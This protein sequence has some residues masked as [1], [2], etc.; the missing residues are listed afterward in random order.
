MGLCFLVV[1]SFSSNPPVWIRYTSRRSWAFQLLS[2]SLNI[3]GGRDG[4][5]TFRKFVHSSLEFSLHPLVPLKKMHGL[6]FLLVVIL[7][8]QLMLDNFCYIPYSFSF[9]FSYV[10]SSLWVGVFIALLL[11]LHFGR[12]RGKWVC[13]L[14]QILAEAWI[15]SQWHHKK[16]NM[17]MCVS[18]YISY[19]YT[20]AC[21]TFCDM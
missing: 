20:N 18:L 13:S 17:Y 4:R 21:M 14:C 12:R 7:L 19:Y 10:T 9:L 8:Y 6:H 16:N 3:C 5:D 1:F 2:T 11:H 15:I